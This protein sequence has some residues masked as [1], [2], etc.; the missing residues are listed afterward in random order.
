MTGSARLR[1]WEPSDEG[2]RRRASFAWTVTALALTACVMGVFVRR[3]WEYPPDLPVLVVLSAGLVRGSA[4]GATVGF[5]CG[6]FLDLAP[7]AAHVAGTAALGYCLAGHLAG[8]L[9]GTVEPRLRRG[10]DP[11]RQAPVVAV[12]AVVPAAIALLTTVVLGGSATPSMLLHA[13]AV[14]AGPTIPAGL[15]AVPLLT[16]VLRRC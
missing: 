2:P 3:T 13:L 14:T 15:P 5:A 16:W 7:A 10:R 4:A 11:L 12:G 6:L 8:R 9:A 1:P